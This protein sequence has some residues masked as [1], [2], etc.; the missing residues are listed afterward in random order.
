MSI[1]DAAERVSVQMQRC[2]HGVPP[3]GPKRSVRIWHGSCPSLDHGLRTRL[4]PGRSGRTRRPAAGGR[5]ARPPAE[6][7]GVDPTR[8]ARPARRR[9]AGDR[10]PDRD[11]RVGRRGV[12]ARRGRS[13]DPSCVTTA[14]AASARRSPPPPARAASP[15]AAP[16]RCRR[17]SASPG[18]RCSAPTRS[19]HRSGRGARSRRPPAARRPGS[20]RPRR[21][22]A[23]RPSSVTS[24]PMAGA[25]IE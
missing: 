12:R 14:A 18:R 5:R 21:R 3:V 22:R 23:A 1:K 11:T 7:V 24:S 6:H 17:R 9:G 8:I 16:R 20:S 4:P 19:S 10:V 2:G 25:A 13:R 15:S